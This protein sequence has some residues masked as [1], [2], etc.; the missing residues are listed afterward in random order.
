M[1]WI[2]WSFSA[3][4]LIGCGEGTSGTDLCK[5]VFVPY[6]DMISQRTRTHMNATYVDGM[7]EYSQ[8]NYAAARDSIEKFL[9]VQ[10]ADVTGYMYLACSY[11]A[12]GDPYKA[13]LQLDHLEK[14][15]ILHYDDQIE[16]YTVVCWLCSGQTDRARAGAE[17]IV[18]EGTHTYVREAKELLA[19]LPATKP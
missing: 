11:I 8:G 3:V 7:A 2:W 15:D 17:R 13:E 4:V 10:R 5:K 9:R 19:E 16:W 6:P 1:R 12:L 18:S 14:R